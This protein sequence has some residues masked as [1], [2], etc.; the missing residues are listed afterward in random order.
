MDRRDF[1]VVVAAG[2]DGDG[3]EG[4]LPLP[5]GLRLLGGLLA[6]RRC[7]PF[8]VCCRGFHRLSQRIHGEAIDGAWRA[9]HVGPVADHGCAARHDL[10][11]WLFPAEMASRPFQAGDDA[12]MGNDD[13][14]GADAGP[15]DR[16]TAGADPL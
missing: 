5:L 7:R 13:E 11:E 10:T 8:V 3:R 9:G 6:S 4:L 14:I 15:R 16:A 2:M 12:V 1:D